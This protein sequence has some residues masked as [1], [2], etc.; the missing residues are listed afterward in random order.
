[1]NRPTDEG[2]AKPIRTETASV[3][4]GLRVD[5]IGGLIAGGLS[6]AGVGLM[7]LIPL[8]WPLAFQETSV[9]TGILWLLTSL[10]LCGT[11]GLIVANRGPLPRLLTATL[12]G[13]VGIMALWSGFRSGMELLGRVLDYGLLE[14]LIQIVL[15]AGVVLVLYTLRH[16]LAGLARR[17]VEVGERDPLTGLLNRE[18]I[19][20]R[21]NELRRGTPASIIM[22]DVND[23]DQINEVE[24]YGAGDNRLR[25]VARAIEA[26][27]PSGAIAARW[28]GD[29][30]LVLLPG[31]HERTALDLASRLQVAV[32]GPRPNRLPFSV[33]VAP[34]PGGRPLE[35]SI[36]TADGRMYEDKETQ[37]N[38]EA[39]IT[40]ERTL[41]GF[42]EFSSRLESLSEVEE[43]VADGLAMTRELLGFD[44]C[45]CIERAER[46]IYILEHLD[47]DLEEGMAGMIGKLKF[48]PGKG[49]IGRAIQAGY[50][51]Y[52]SDYTDDPEAVGENNFKGLVVKS[53]VVVPVR[54][55][56]KV[57]AVVGLFSYNRW[58]PIT[59]RVRRAIEAVALR[60]QH[61][62][63]RDS[64]VN[65][66]RR[67]LENGLLAIGLA[68]EAR[69]L[70]T[71]GHT[72]R[73]VHLAE[74]LG[75]EMGVRGREMD[76]LRKGAY[77]HDMGKLSIPDAVLL[78]KGKLDAA[79]WAIM[80]S[81]TVIGHNNASRIPSLE[82]GALNVI[83]FHHE[84][85]DGTGYP[86][87]LSGTN[88]PLGARIFAICDVWDALT[89]L[90]PYKKAWSEQAA[91]T[92]L[93][94]LSGSH[95]DPE[96]VTAFERVVDKVQIE[97]V[98]T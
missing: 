22:V 72:E 15:T 2:K 28:G 16:E 45:F 98:D 68:L 32:P 59:P 60:L 19:T 47:G 26:A 34:A 24:G 18:G 31:R 73:V 55:A 95:F 67:T 57:V 43:I 46:D 71:A 53:M 9:I 82:K 61:A 49:L 93:R 81:H 80:Q 12:G 77:L 87:R 89:S 52:S 29:E 50:T 96:V 35:R 39:E 42:E 70:E 10:G 36:A 30:F 51:L 23:L 64:A 37:R 94:R 92:E 56:G 65:E 11:L 33:G 48:G 5:R 85:W 6:V 69:D 76:A 74:L 7:L 78:K 86:D 83:R 41:S 66:I 4:P 21:Y 88:I 20:R 3:R 8:G 58:R 40:G 62:L 17:E 44:G 1:M 54:D 84:R 63:E 13:I 97:L 91:L 79:E 75:S 25:Q 90:R 14:M 38:A 27:L